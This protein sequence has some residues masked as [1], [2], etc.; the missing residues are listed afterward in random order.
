M[1]RLPSFTDFFRDVHGFPPFP[2][3]ADLS[4][5]VV[6]TGWPALLDLPTG[7]G[8]TSTLDLALY[9]LAADPGCAPRRV[10]LVVDR[11]I[12]VDQGARHAEKI[13]RRFREGAAPA[14]AQALRRLWGAPS[15][16]DPFHVAVLRGG[17]PGDHDWARR[18]DQPVLGVSTV[19][20]VGS[21]LLFR[22]YGVSDRMAPVHAGL[23]GNDVLLLM[24]EVHLA[25]PF[26]ETLEAISLRWRRNA[27]EN[28]FQFVRMSATPG[29]ATGDVFRLGPADHKDPTLSKRLQATKPTRLEEV[30][31]KGD[32]EAR[33][34][35][36]AQRCAQVAGDLVDDGAHVVA[37][38]VNRVNTAREIWKEFAARGDVALD[39]VLIT[40]RMR[41]LDRDR[42]LEGSEG[43]LART[44]AEMPRGVRPNPRPLVV[45]S[46]QC[47]E[48]GADFDF[49]GLVTEC[50]SLDALRQRFGRLDRKGEFGKARAAVLIRS[51]QV[52]PRSPDPVY[53]E[54][55]PKT[56]AWLAAQ[57]PEMDFGI[58]S[59][60]AI[61][62]PDDSLHE[63]MPAP[64]R[65]P[66]LLPAHLDAWVQ[67]APRPRPDPEVALW[68]HGP[69][70]GAPEVLLVWRA[71]V[72]EELLDR[73]ASSDASREGALQT[74][75]ER[76]SAC[77][78]TALEAMSIPIYAARA[79]L[80][81][82]GAPPVDDLVNAAG[83]DDPL[84]RGDG[85]HVAI[86]W[87]GQ[88]ARVVQASD[89]RP[90]ETLVIP[91][92][93]GGIQAGN[94]DPDHHEM[95]TDLG[96]LAQWVARGRI[97]LR[98]APTT[99]A[100]WG[101]DGSELGL[102]PGWDPE[103]VGDMT[104]ETMRWLDDIAD[105]GSSGA[106]AKAWGE[107]RVGLQEGHRILDLSG[108][109]YMLY[110]PRRGRLGPSTDG[111]SGS[112]TERM[113]TLP[114]HSGRVRAWI[115][116]F[117]VGLGLDDRLAKDL[118][119]AAWFHDVGKLDPR[120]QLWLSDG[121]PVKQALNDEPLA[122]SS[123]SLRSRRERETARHR[124]GYPSG[125]R[126]EVLSAALIQE[127]PALDQAHDRDLVL[128]LVA[129]HHGWCRPF[130]PA[131]ADP[132]PAWVAFQHGNQQLEGTTDH[133]LAKLDSGVS[134]RFWVLTDR[135][136]RWGL[137]WLEAIL[138]LADHRASEEEGE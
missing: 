105:C 117:I 9:A 74:L 81:A 83:T 7:S 31:V 72:E 138:R 25:Q 121:N 48:A 57:R 50:A 90:G 28:R 1:N 104:E 101:L 13:L 112:F 79:W 43:V 130:A 26:A 11:R 40:G 68:L 16:E 59:L 44:G 8:K 91:A 76:L 47:I 21:R 24:D 12:V 115:Q 4:E 114:D 6:R 97:G 102:I 66:V 109:H 85:P 136:G 88:V 73:A 18:P 111:D 125:Y 75:S 29:D 30:R 135:Y 108:G 51:D 98:M 2:W 110:V 63:L 99:L 14:I 32:E 128:H 46:T 42:V 71:D 34:R 19:D 55:L 39:A 134:E 94:W 129:S 127:N 77:P 122:K 126:H 52:A 53:G 84:E 38:V 33:S 89:I 45:I 100:I 87:D 35:K 65:A 92:T 22:G 70:V 23:I 80:R 17:I 131:V 113:I 67:T 61:L 124:S 123:G 62:P 56:W 69:D 82:A 15:S 103:S 96:D 58:S 118:L 95:V 49:D 5:R 41:P 120:C 133:G 116:R 54:A 132:S 106:F 60:E 27:L 137:A 20:Q 107:L 3:Q 64:K 78:P 10:F 37:V 36:F 86:S 119:L 93:R